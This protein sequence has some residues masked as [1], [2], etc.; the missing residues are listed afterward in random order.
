MPH[1]DQIN[2]SV[3]VRLDPNGQLTD[4]SVIWNNNNKKFELGTGTGI[5]INNPADNRITTATS[6]PNT[7]NAESYFR[8]V[9]TGQGTDQNGKLQIGN[10]TAVPLQLVDI[11]QN[12]DTDNQVIISSTDGDASFLRLG[13]DSTDVLVAAFGS[14]QSTNQKFQIGTYP[15]ETST[16]FTPYL[17]MNHSGRVGISEGSSPILGKSNIDSNYQLLVTRNFTNTNNSA[18]GS[19]VSTVGIQNSSSTNSNLV[20]VLQLF[21]GTDAN[22]MVPTGEPPENGFSGQPSTP[23]WIEFYA[24]SSNST[25]NNDNFLMA[26]IAPYHSNF[27]SFGAN[28]VHVSDKRLKKDIKPLSVGLN[29][30]LKIQPVDYKWK[31][32][33]SP[34]RGFIAQDLYKVYP[35]AVQPSITD[36]PK[37]EP[38]GVMADKL[39]PLLVKSIQ[40]QQEIIENLK[41]RI[42]KLENNK[43]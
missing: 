8:W 13:M 30:L 7:L 22:T 1:N 20:K 27:G 40:E 32:N 34:D 12:T 43:L 41:T 37:E 21:T 16:T 31:R 14:K 11:G 38:W 9:A 3:K 29:E 2:Y 39:I 24:R 5:T 18:P 25:T 10:A 6:D 42:N 35:N 4:Q 26:Y 15:D 33:S 36:D 19:R 17:S 23:R 28:F